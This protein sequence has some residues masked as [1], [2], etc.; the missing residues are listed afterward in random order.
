MPWFEWLDSR[1]SSDVRGCRQ[2]APIF[3]QALF[4]FALV[5]ALAAALPAQAQS[6]AAKPPANAASRNLAPGFAGLPR[7]GSLV[8]MPIDVELFSLSA[9]GMPEPRA[10][11]TSAAQEH[12]RAALLAEQSR[13]MPSARVLG[14]AE[15]D[16]YAEQLALQAAVARSIALHHAG[17][18]PMALPTKENQLRWNLGDALRGISERTGARYG[19]FIWVRDSYA[20]NERKAAM[21]MMAMMGVALTGG[22]Q[23]GYASLVDLQTG[24]VLWFNQMLRMSGDLREATSARE[25]INSLLAS[26]PPLQ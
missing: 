24:D 12:M 4:S 9:G 5:L 6:A 20:S 10:D 18:A 16:E 14:E 22:T 15:A 1:Y 13:L 8:I 23:L 7:D 26:F 25:S 21:V 11:W 19:L 17:M 2:A 3:A